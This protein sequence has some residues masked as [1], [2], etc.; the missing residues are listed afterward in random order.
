MSMERPIIRHGFPRADELP[1]HGADPIA[2]GR[3]VDED[4]ALENDMRD[5][6]TEAS[7]QALQLNERRALAQLVTEFVRRRHAKRALP[8]AGDAAITWQIA[9]LLGQIAGR[10]P[11]SLDP[12]LDDE[13]VLPKG[14][15]INTA[16]D[17]TLRNGA[18]KA[19]GKPAGEN[20]TAAAT[21]PAAGTES[22]H[23]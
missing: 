22:T 5:A 4:D 7:A 12:A 11:A 10:E 3:R 9:D 15:P 1:G 23:G 2:A 17:R 16:V 20:R 13:D 18:R 6:V 14:P 21:A 8:S 19:T